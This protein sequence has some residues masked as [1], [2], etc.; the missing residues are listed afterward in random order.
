MPDNIQQDETVT[1]QHDQPK[2]TIDD[3]SYKIEVIRPLILVRERMLR[4]NAIKNNAKVLS[5]ELCPAM[6][7]DIKLPH[8]RYEIKQLLAK[9]EEDNPKFFASLQ[10]SFSNIQRD[11]FFTPFV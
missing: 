8:V 5:D 1:Q 6:R 3:T 11:T 7:F 9:I 4:D 2:Y 10:S